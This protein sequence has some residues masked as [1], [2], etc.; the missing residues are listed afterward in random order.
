ME[1]CCGTGKCLV[2]STINYHCASWGFG[3]STIS[4]R[5]LAYSLLKILSATRCR[6]TKF[7]WNSEVCSFRGDADRGWLGSSRWEEE[8]RAGIVSFSTFL[9]ASHKWS[10]MRNLHCVVWTFNMSN[11]FSSVFAVLYYSFFSLFFFI[12]FHTHILPYRTR[13]NEMISVSQNE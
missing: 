6:N 9:V 11:I 1:Q 7:P 4:L 8:N 3:S 12:F 13:T 10:W 2:E 5:V